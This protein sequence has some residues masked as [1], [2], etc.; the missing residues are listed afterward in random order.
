MKLIDLIRLR[1]LQDVVF[2]AEIRYDCALDRGL[3]VIKS[4]EYGALMG[5]CRVT[6]SRYEDCINELRAKYQK[7]DKEIERAEDLLIHLRSFRGYRL[8][9]WVFRILGMSHYV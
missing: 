3:V 6:R 2:E 4:Q 1:R 7:E 8:I 9:R 5:A